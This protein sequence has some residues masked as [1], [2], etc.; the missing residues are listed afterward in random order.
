MS[1]PALSRKDRLRGSPE[2][3]HEEGSPTQRAQFRAFARKIINN[4]KYQDAVEK[5][6]ID[7]TESPAVARLLLEAA[8]CSVKVDEGRGAEE[9]ELAL[10]MRA[11]VA[12]LSR[13]PRARE[14][15]ARVQGA[16]RILELPAQAIR[17]VKR[18]DGTT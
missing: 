13:S 12:E 11:M 2:T 17:E 8:F 6:M 14:L 18:D 4:P 10:K 15:D 5:R 16:R 7:G 1:V 9:A 3:L